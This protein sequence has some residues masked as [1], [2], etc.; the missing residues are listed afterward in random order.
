MANVRGSGAKNRSKKKTDEP[1]KYLSKGRGSR[2]L[3]PKW[4]AWNKKKTDASDLKIRQKEN[5]EEQRKWI[6]TEN[7]DGTFTTR[8]RTS[9]DNLDKISKYTTKKK[10]KIDPYTRK[11]EVTSES[12]ANKAANTKLNIGSSKKEGNKVENS[13]TNDT[14]GTSDSDK[15]A[16]IAKHEKRAA[17]Q[18]ST[19]SKLKAAKFSSEELWKL[20][21]KKR[22]RLSIKNG[23]K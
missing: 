10:D 14:G 11:S 6:R 18:G 21:K 15:K 16:W 19:A 12:A 13:K 7:P 5:E 17:R 2:V 4:T 3:N 23:K 1:P 9:L 22:D 8:K 20:Q